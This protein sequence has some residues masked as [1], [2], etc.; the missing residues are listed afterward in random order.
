[1][2]LNT[3]NDLLARIKAGQR[4]RFVAFGSSNTDRRIHGLHWFD[5][6]DLGLKHIFGRVVHSINAGTGGDTTRDLLR[7]FDEDVALYQPHAVFIT[8]G[9]NDAN[10]EK[11]L[12]AEEYRDNLGVLVNQVR[13]LGAVPI[14]QTYYAAD[15]PNLGEPHASNFQRN[16]QIIRDVAAAEAC[17]LVDHHARWE[18]LRVQHPDLFASLMLDALHINPT[19]NA[20]M[21]L[22]L[23]RRL[24][25][26]L[27]PEQWA[28]L[29]GAR[30][31][32]ALMD[33]LA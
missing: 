28:F 22:D 16:M 25:V 13:A 20:I 19:G 8:I 21:G 12:G 30:A 29:H 32:Q 1:M 10:P 3:I 11:A 27:N 5:W 4:T 33:S 31:Y 9:G 23:C 15:L 2:P 24:Q 6:L 14:L 17:E 18:P 7:R 26:Q